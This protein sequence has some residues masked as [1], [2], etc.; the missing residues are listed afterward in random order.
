MQIFIEKEEPAKGGSCELLRDLFTVF[1][2]FNL[3]VLCGILVLWFSNESVERNGRRLRRRTWGSI[4][5]LLRPT[6]I[7]SITT[8]YTRSKGLRDSADLYSVASSVKGWGW[9]CRFAWSGSQQ[10]EE[11]IRRFHVWIV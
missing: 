6:V 11:K 7:L 10:N 1:L 2:I 8:V 3:K 5:C 9:Q 4:K